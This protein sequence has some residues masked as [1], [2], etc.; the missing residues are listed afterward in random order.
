MQTNKRVKFESVAVVGAMA[1]MAFGATSQAQAA[2]GDWTPAGAKQPSAGF[3]PA[4]YHP[5]EQDL[6]GFLQVSDF[7]RTASIVGLWKFEWLS[8]GK[9]AA[10]PPK[11]VLLDFGLQAWHD[12]GTE[13]INSGNQNPV[14][15]NFCLGAWRQVGRHSYVVKHMPLAYKGGSYVGPVVITE[16][17]T[18]SQSGNSFTGHLTLTPYLATNM[19][20]HEFDLTTP[21]VPEAITGTITGTRLVAGY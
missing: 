5:G 11:G 15:S 13:I 9:S 20:G 3:A 19:P 21:L 6:A 17:I 8:D 7:E 2:C 4:V 1:F 18:L 12:D 10:G 14:D 16:S